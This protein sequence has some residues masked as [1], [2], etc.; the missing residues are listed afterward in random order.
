MHQIDTAC[1]LPM[2]LV[3]QD[4]HLIGRNSEGSIKW[5]DNESVMPKE[6]AA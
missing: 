5:E 4:G 6:T 3:D 1:I 2:P